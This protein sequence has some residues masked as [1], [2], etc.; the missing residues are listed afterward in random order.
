MASKN[1]PNK[2]TT[3]NI[4]CFICDKSIS[5]EQIIINQNSYCKDC[6]VEVLLNNKNDNS[7]NNDIKNDNLQIEN[8]KKASI[9]NANNNSDIEKK[10]ERYLDDLYYDEKNDGIK[11]K[12]NKKHEPNLKKQ[13]LSYEL[14]HG[15][16]ASIP[17]EKSY[18]RNPDKNSIFGGDD[19]K[20]DTERN[21]NKSNE[22]T[23]NK[24][25]SFNDTGNNDLTDKYYI[26]TEANPYPNLSVVNKKSLLDD[27]TK[28][29]IKKQSPNREKIKSI[30]NENKQSFNKNKKSSVDNK[31]PSL[32]NKKTIP[33]T[34]NKKSVPIS[35][36]HHKLHNKSVF[37]H[38]NSKSNKDNDSKFIIIIIIILIVFMLFIIAHGISLITGQS[39]L[40]Y[41][42]QLKL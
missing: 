34:N 37:D 23:Y 15:S 24:S 41:F 38:D 12:K 27:N 39:I 5:Q 18:L 7:Q 21:N 42:N 6:A 13:L 32:E 9:N 14:D 8:N 3:D 35:S 1:H 40:D 26:K 20:Q 29:E 22:R 19:K 36:Q 31:Q 33:E 30:N 16:I 25:N 4:K 2:E 28:R 10:Y 17:P 11:T